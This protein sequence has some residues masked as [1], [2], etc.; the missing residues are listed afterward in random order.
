MKDSNRCIR[1]LANPVQLQDCRN[2][3]SEAQHPI[4]NISSILN[5]AGNEVRLKIMFLLQREGEMCPCDLSDVLGMTVPAI[6]QHLKKMKE[7][8]VVT[9]RKVGQTIFYSMVEDPQ[10]LITKVLQ[11]LMNQPEVKS[12]L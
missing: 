1:V 9:D 11:P 12:E 10:S 3:L 4:R 5:L 6:S 8:S 2:A 7:G